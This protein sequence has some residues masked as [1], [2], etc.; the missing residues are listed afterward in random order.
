M[1]HGLPNG[2]VH[3]MQRLM[4]DEWMELALALQTTAPFRGL[5]LH[6]WTQAA[7]NSQSDVLRTSPPTYA[8]TTPVPMPDVIAQRVLNPVPW[9]TDAFYIPKDSQLGKTIYHEAG[10]FYIQEPSAMAVAT[11]LDARPG[12][13]VLDLCAAPGGK[14]TA[15]AR[16]MRGQGVLVANEIHP[17]RVLTLAQNLERLGIPAVVVNESPER[18]AM[19]WS[20]YFD[21][22]LV[23]A[24]CSGEGMFRKDILARE[25]W[26]EEAPVMC[27]SRQRDILRAAVR[28]VKKGGRL[29]YSTCTLNAVENEQVVDWAVRELPLTLTALPN[30]PQWSDGRPEWGS[31]NPMLKLTKRLWPHLGDG[32]G[33]F[34]AAFTVS[35]ATEAEAV[36]ERELGISAPLWRGK[37]NQSQQTDNDR[38]LALAKELLTDVPTAWQTTVS[39]GDLLFASPPPGLVTTGLKVLRPGLCLAEISGT[40]VQPHHSLAMAVHPDLVRNKVELPPDLAAN[41]MAGN[42]LERTTSPGYNLMM[43]IGAIPLGWGKGVPGRINNLYPRGL[44]RQGLLV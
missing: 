31:G 43:S 6:R 17:K 10:A 25:E 35:E 37:R 20:G 5:R 38:W 8:I 22:V 27:A 16:A 19:T 39:R 9:M 41:Y 18:L 28:M 12:H 34:V 11:A 42:A 36:P 33:H 32:E 24:P 3:Q 2:F 1:E 7:N 13:H 21:A 44:R 23:D 4:G 14:T 40:R 15:L 30:W 29:V 26:T